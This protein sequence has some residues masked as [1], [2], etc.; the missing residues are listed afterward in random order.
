MLSLVGDSA[1]PA[2]PSGITDAQADYLYRV[3]MAQDE[4]K[5]RAGMRKTI[6]LLERMPDPVSG[7][8]NGNPGA[9][10]SIARFAAHRRE[11]AAGLKLVA[12]DAAGAAQSARE[13]LTK[14][15]R[16][17]EYGKSFPDQVQAIK[18][19]LLAVL[20]KAGGAPAAKEFVDAMTADAQSPDEPTRSFLLAQI[21]YAQAHGGDADGALRTMARVKTD[22]QPTDRSLQPFHAVY[23]QIGLAQLGHDDAAAYKTFDQANEMMRETA[24][25]EWRE[26]SYWGWIAQQCAE[27]GNLTAVPALLDKEKKL[28]FNPVHLLGI[29][30]LQAHAGDTD[31]MVRT[32]ARL[33]GQNVT[34]YGEIE[35]LDRMLLN[36]GDYKSVARL[37]DAHLWSSLETNELVL[38]QAAGAGDVEFVLSHLNGLTVQSVERLAKRLRAAG[39]PD[40]AREVL[41]R[42][43]EHQITLPETPEREI[44]CASLA[45]SLLS[46]GFKDEALEIVKSF[47]SSPA[48][49]AATQP[50]APRYDPFVRRAA[51]VPGLAFVRT[52]VEAGD[53]DGALGWA[54]SLPAPDARQQ[55]LIGVADAVLSPIAVRG[56]T[57]P[58]SVIYQPSLPATG[59]RSDTLTTRP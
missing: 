2:D 31:G 30:E 49:D 56:N 37:W 35:R 9:E 32:L 25:A 27:G 16:L 51:F 57:Q 18:S 12:G 6:T 23:A 28:P 19:G 24:S 41:E 54:Q 20:A 3:A 55:A 44:N 13:A 40:A 11:R 4:L 1:P 15:P 48:T 29:A 7:A 34:A 46:H 38:A 45:A 47:Q 43:M 50:V 33:D 59:P 42:M 36:T 52:R 14:I 8:G 22:H 53:F 39:H 5:D 10:F 17:T 26:A 58:P 21:A